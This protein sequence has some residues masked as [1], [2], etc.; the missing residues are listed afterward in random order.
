MMR[1]T[2]YL[3][4]FFCPVLLSAQTEFGIR[5]GMFN[6]KFRYF[7]DDEHFLDSDEIKRLEVGIFATIKISKRLSVE[8]EI[9]FLG[10]GGKTPAASGSSPATTIMQQVEVVAPLKYQYVHKG[11]FAF[12][13]GGATYGH[14]VSGYNER[15]VTGRSE[16]EFDN[17]HLR[18]PDLGFV[19]GGGIGMLIQKSKFFVESRYRQSILYTSDVNLEDFKFSTKN[20]GWGIYLCYARSFSKE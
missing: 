9:N 12:V 6:A 11:F 5:A 8:P 10:K 14:F 20:R 13:K 15:P 4:A 7:S 2:Y 19:V 16:L 1:C 17:F 3:I 18:R